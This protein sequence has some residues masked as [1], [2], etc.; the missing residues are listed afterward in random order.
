M[1]GVAKAC[2]F[3]NYEFK[4]LENQGSTTVEPRN[5]A[6][7]A[8]GSF[9]FATINGG[10]TCNNAT[11]GDPAPASRRPAIKGSETITPLERPRAER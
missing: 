5:I 6:Y 3:A 10:F 2:Y 4:A 11:F 8:N 9:Y 7:G 1:Q